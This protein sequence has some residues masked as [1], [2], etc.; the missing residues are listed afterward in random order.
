MDELKL[1]EILPAATGSVKA[2][3]GAGGVMLD[4]ALGRVDA[5]RV[6]AA[7]LAL[8][9]DVALVGAVSSIVRSGTAVDLKVH[10]VADR[11]GDLA[12][13]AAYDVAIGVENASIDIPVPVMTLTGASGKVRI[14]RGTLTASNVAGTFDA[15]SLRA[16]ELVL[17]LS[18]TVAV[19]SLSVALDIDL[20]ESHGRLLRMLRDSPLAEEM[21]RV[22]SIAG[23]VKGTFAL[24]QEGATLR[25]I[26]DVTGINAKL[27]Y[28]SMPLPV[29]I[30][31]GGVH[32]ETGGTLVLRKVAG[33]IGASHIEQINEEV[34]FAPGPV[35]CAPARA[36]RRSR[37]TSSTRGRSRFRR[38]RRSAARSP[39]CRDRPE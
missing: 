11:V 25:Q 20:A 3:P 39:R 2:R 35:A 15:S 30:D 5:G 17:A 21:R 6:R 7:A 8:A 14:A 31:S 18:P 27:R 9:S 16:G 22:E 19:S 33:A 29:A 4:A 23:G 37:W 24:R 10:A 12:D 1:G 32:Y 13:V 36:R 26:Y 38:S 28:V 34:A